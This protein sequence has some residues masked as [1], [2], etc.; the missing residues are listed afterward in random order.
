MRNIE[1]N[2]KNEETEPCLLLPIV[3]AE[4]DCLLKQ[5]G[6]SWLAAEITEVDFDWWSDISREGF[7]FTHLASFA[8]CIRKISPSLD[9]CEIHMT[10]HVYSGFFEIDG[11]IRERCAVDS[12]SRLMWNKLPFDLLTQQCKSCNTVHISIVFFKK[13][14]FTRKLWFFAALTVC[15][16]S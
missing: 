3:A 14:G 12:L 6:T 11:M 9:K 13:A 8:V 5:S 10:F 2:V 1:H 7:W 15:H 4:V 16:S